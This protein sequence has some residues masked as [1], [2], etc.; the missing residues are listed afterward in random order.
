MAPDRTVHSNKA[1]QQ[2]QSGP[3]SSS[4]AYTTPDLS[5]Q[6]AD[7]FGAVV[8][9]AHYLPEPESCH[10]TPEHP[11]G[12]G[13]SDSPDSGRPSTLTSNSFLA[14]LATGSG[15]SSHGPAHLPSLQRGAAC[16]TCRQ[17][18]IK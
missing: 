1:R 14:S 12:A 11:A 7:S 17:R 2:S 3:S 5:F 4:S 18:K 9:L 10:H 15:L 16:L 6:Q 13:R 8:G